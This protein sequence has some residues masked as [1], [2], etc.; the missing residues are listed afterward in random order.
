M[1]QL[2]TEVRILRSLNHPNVIKLEGGKEGFFIVAVDVEVRPSP[3]LPPIRLLD[4][5]YDR[6]RERVNMIFEYLS[7]R[8][9]RDVLCRASGRLP[10]ATVQV[11]SRRTT[12]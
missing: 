7:Q 6:A 8:S 12:L 3:H 4:F 10:L 9:V 2:S 11:R 1:E 5:T